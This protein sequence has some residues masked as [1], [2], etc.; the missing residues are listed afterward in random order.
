MST[1]PDIEISLTWRSRHVTHRDRQFV[2]GIDPR[3][4]HI[5]A[6]DLAPLATA[7]PGEGIRLAESFLVTE[8][9]ATELRQSSLLGWRHS[10]PLIGRHYPRGL[11]NEFPRRDLR[12][13]RV[14]AV[15]PTAVLADFNPPLAGVACTVDAKIVTGS[16][17]ASQPWRDT[18]AF[19]FGG[20]GMQAAPPDT[21]TDFFAGTPFA[22]A[23]DSDD[24]HFYRRE[25]LVDHLDAPTR[26][27]LGHVYRRFLRPGMA[28]LD[29][30]ASWN[31][32][33][34]EDLDLA[35]TGLGMNPAELAH[36][37]R[38]TTR[39]I[40]DL[41][42]SPAMPF[43][44]ACFGAALCALSIE[45]LTRPHDVVGEVARVLKSGAPFVITFSDRWFP[46]KAIRLWSELHPF[47][48]LALVADYLRLSGQFESIQTESLR[49]LP[50][51]SGAWRPKERPFA[52]P[53]FA[54]WGYRVS[55]R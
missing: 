14:V 9:I 15:E 21:D 3:R 2:A 42:Q 20:P 18:D 28:V 33:L 44:D 51:P 17:A 29:L 55:R 30:M 32:H 43:P 53:L 10:P 54:T 19:L 6:L 41:N 48:R 39:V 36:N 5:F 23:D 52:D 26:A 16:F 24:A 25:R 11:L 47:E 38:L 12:P 46:T 40:H 37:P 1:M 4:D 7:T 31:S 45:Y 27:E 49:G 8:R 34:P 35:V 13:F 22:R 50:A